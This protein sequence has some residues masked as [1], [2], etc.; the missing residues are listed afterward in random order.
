MSQAEAPANQSGTAMGTHTA[1]LVCLG[2]LALAIAFVSATDYCKK[3]CG[4]T[5]NLGCN[6]TGVSVGIILEV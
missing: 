4:N 1:N 2:L 5:Q 6:N 3:K